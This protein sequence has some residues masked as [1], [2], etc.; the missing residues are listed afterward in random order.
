MPFVL[1]SAAYFIKIDPPPQLVPKNG[2]FLALLLN[3][4]SSVAILFL[5]TKSA[6][7]YITALAYWLVMSPIVMALATMISVTAVFIFHS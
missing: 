3:L 7:K 4:P 5:P 6:R 2:Y 1:I